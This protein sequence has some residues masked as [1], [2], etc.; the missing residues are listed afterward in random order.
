MHDPLRLQIL[1]ESKSF[2]KS[3]EHGAVV[4]VDVLVLLLVVFVNVVV[5]VLELVVVMVSHPLQVLS[6]SPGEI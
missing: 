3:L 1:S 2:S 4:V 6:Q 5:D